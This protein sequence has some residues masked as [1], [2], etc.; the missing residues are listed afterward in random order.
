MLKAAQA[1]PLAAEPGRVAAYG[2]LD[3]SVLA[4]VLEKAGGRPYPD[5]VRDRVWKPAG[6]QATAFDGALDPAPD[7][8]T[9]EVVPGRVPVYPWQGD[10]QRTFWFHHP[11]HA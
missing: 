8:R 6:L 9:S 2:S 3:Y 4:L 1:Q 11:A 7:L 10:R 5:L